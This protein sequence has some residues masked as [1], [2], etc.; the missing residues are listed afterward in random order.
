MFHQTSWK[1]KITIGEKINHS[2]C[3][4]TWQKS[5]K[6]FTL[7]EPCALLGQVA[8]RDTCRM[9]SEWCPF[10][11]LPHQR[12]KRQ[13]CSCNV[14]TPYCTAPCALE[15]Q[16]GSLTSSKSHLTPDSERPSFPA[17]PSKL[18]FL[19]VLRVGSRWLLEGQECLPSWLTKATFHRGEQVSVADIT[20]TKR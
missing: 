18:S 3:W 14:L 10:R 15:G 6:I 5:S 12:P 16:I 13:F 19:Q 8:C 9:M 11:Q 2:L 20:E 4:C 1:N 17:A 7:R